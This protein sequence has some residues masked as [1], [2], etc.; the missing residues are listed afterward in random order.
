[1]CGGGSQFNVCG[2]VQNNNL[3]SGYQFAGAR[4]VGEVRFPAAVSQL[5]G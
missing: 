3:G 4:F 2:G 1:M 5:K